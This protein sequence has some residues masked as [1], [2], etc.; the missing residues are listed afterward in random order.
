MLREQLVAFHKAGNQPI[1]DRPQ[2]PPDDRMRLRLSLISEEFGELL[3]AA[4]GTEA[5]AELRIRLRDIVGDS[6]LQVDLV[7]LTDA[8]ADL[9]Y[10]VEGTRLECGING[11]PIAAEVHRANMAKFGPGSW[12]R[13]DGK[14]MKPPGWTPPDIEGK[15]RE[16][17]WKPEAA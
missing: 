2:V 10:V 13:G 7:G 3:E 4:L 5:T 11:G 6:P 16:Q 12:I 17:G 14:V 15:L 9:D 8:M 1:L